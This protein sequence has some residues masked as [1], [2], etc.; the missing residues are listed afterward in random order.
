MKDI[1]ME[2]IPE[3]VLKKIEDEL[4]DKPTG[5]H[6][7]GKGANYDVYKFTLN[8]RVL[9]LRIQM[10]AFYD[11]SPVESRVLKEL[12]GMNAPELLF[13]DNGNSC[14]SPFMIQSFIEGN[15]VNNLNMEQVEQVV[16]KISQIHDK[17]SKKPRFSRIKDYYDEFYKEKFGNQFDPRVLSNMV[18]KNTISRMT[19][20]LHYRLKNISEIPAD[21]ECLIHGD[22]NQNNLIW[23]ENSVSFIDW[24]LS[25]YSIPEIE[26]GG[27]LYCH[28]K[29]RTLF[30]NILNLFSQ[31]T[32]PLIVTSFY[33]RLLD[34]ICWRVKYL[35]ETKFSKQEYEEQI[36][37]FNHDLDKFNYVD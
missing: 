28:G 25:R 10:R 7:I 17:T 15:I 8:D 12:D 27:L 26:F 34:T 2:T 9:V 14:G 21:F 19:D 6:L 5:F 33:L 11:F 30:H 36:S 4:K 13:Y 29:D 20:T 1:G 3:I 37:Y 16:L 23:Q 31:A 35:K 32:Q 22:L 24:E 18:D